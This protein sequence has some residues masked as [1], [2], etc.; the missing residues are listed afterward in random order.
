MTTNGKERGYFVQRAAEELNL[1]RESKDPA[2]AAIHKR[3]A[4]LYRERAG[5]MADEDKK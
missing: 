5:A 3:L 1:V 4:K 2:A